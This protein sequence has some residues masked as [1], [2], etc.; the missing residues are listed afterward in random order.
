MIK[1]RQVARATRHALI[2]GAMAAISAAIPA[3]A[4]EQQAADE[5][6]EVIV[7]TGS[8]IAAPNSKSASPIVALSDKD[9]KITG[10]TDISDIINQ[11]PQ[12]FNNDLGQDL[13]NRTTGLTSAGGVATADL[14][15]LGPNRTLVLVNGRRLGQGS[16]YTFIQQP[17]PDLDQIPTA[18]VERVEVVT[19]GASATYGSDAIAG[20]VNFI[21][22]TNFEGFQIDGQLGE[23]WHDN[24]NKYTQDA[25]LATG[26]TPLTGTSHDGRNRTFNLIAGTNFADGKGNVTAYFGYLNTDPVTSGDRDFGG[27]QLAANANLDGA[28]CLGSSNSNFFR[29]LTGPN[30]NTVTYSVSGSSFVPRGSVATQVPASFNSQPYIYMQRQDTRYTAGFFVHND[31][32][33][34]ARAYAE[35]GFMND[36][37]H[38]EIAP[39]A[40]FRGSNPNDPLSGNYNINCSNPLLSAQQAAILCTPAQIAADLA[41]PG[42][43]TANVEIGRRNVEGGGRFSDYEHSNYR[44]V[45]GMKG[46]FAQAWS[47]DAY[48]QYYY[49]TFY[50]TNDRYLNFSAI[51]NALLVTGTAA[52]P[53]CI[54]GPPCVPYNI[55]SDGGVTQDQLNYLYLDGTG[56]GTA[57]LRTVHADVTGNLGEYGFKS[58]LATDGIAVNVGYE[59]RNEHVAFKPDSGELS[60]QL[61]GF[62]SA[63]V[64][65]DNGISV[66]EEFIEVRAPLAQDKTGVKDLLFD[67]GF[68]RSDYSTSGAVNTYKFELQYAPV[69]DVRFRGSY[70]RAIRAPSIVELYNP[71]L[72]GL[73]QLGTDPCAPTLDVNNN[74][75]PAA[76]S[77][78][79]CE[80][81]G[82][83]AAQY[84]NGGTTNIIPQA[85]LGQLSQLTGGNPALQPEKAKSYTFGFTLTPRALPNFTAS[86]DYFNI[87]LDG[88]VGTIGANVILSNCLDT[89]NPVYCS[90]LVRRPDNGGLTGNSLASG[91]YI[92]QTNVNVALGGFSGIDVQ[93]GYKLALSPRWGS[94]SFAL[95]GAYLL[96]TTTT[97]QPGAHTYDCAGLYGSTCQTVNPKWH[98]ILRTSWITPWDVTA[99]LTW[100]YIGAVKLDQNDSDPTLHDSAFGA[101]NS[102]NARLPSFSYLDLAASWNL[103]DNLELRGG[104]NNLLDKDPPLASFE[105]TSGGAANTYST[106]DAL[107]RQLFVTFTAKF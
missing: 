83:T 62:G 71:Q 72:V 104:I 60:G 28:F 58:P 92:V 15:G 107:G 44:G 61:S 31:F 27:C 11:L 101:F 64:A 13:G 18:L 2:V 103:R 73:I 95:N 68:R 25:Q 7:V 55:F 34:F 52:N 20:V 23:N 32:T 85:V 57:T 84:G 106:Y 53:R 63:A 41:D 48:G 8:R 77:L 54:S 16:P 17:A 50:N 98:H 82:V 66:S 93:G 29:P 14:R 90:Q 86:V 99:S 42:S 3:I 51:D 37:T 47:Y 40:L 79:D 30:A 24:H 36:R 56:Y 102:F 65:I 10:K 5:S 76:R 43:V 26:Q 100:R 49:T 89:G 96:K 6:L 67:T 78:A 59:N 70:Q 9:I 87:K 94:L 4:Q 105:I 97:P 38:Q 39:S 33:D 35:F 69:E 88:G 19:G 91:G 75:V 46:D 74:L 12:N 80:R 21:M 45:I 22:K 81:T 1:K